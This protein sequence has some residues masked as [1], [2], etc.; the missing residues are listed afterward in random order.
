MGTHVSGRID[1]RVVAVDG[2][3]ARGSKAGGAT[4][5]HLISAFAFGLGATG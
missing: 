3:T 5:L 2:K 4:P 1:G